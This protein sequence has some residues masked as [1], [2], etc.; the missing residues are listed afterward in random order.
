MSKLIGGSKFQLTSTNP[1]PLPGPDPKRNLHK[2]CTISYGLREY[3]LIQDF[4]RPSDVWLNE[5]I[6]SSIEEITDD[7][8]FRDL[9]KFLYDNNIVS[10]YTDEQA[11]TERQE[12]LR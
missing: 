2:V 4:A 5:V 11:E 3:I 9:W 8:L 7:E 1:V 6:G 10:V 12:R